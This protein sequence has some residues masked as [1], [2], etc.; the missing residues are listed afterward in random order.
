MSEV[1][2]PRIPDVR[3][4][5]IFRL[6][7]P[8]AV[9]FELMMLEGPSVQSAMGRL[10]APTLN[11]AAWG[12]A[13]S[14]ALLVESPVI[15]LLATAIALVKDEDSYRALRR[16]VVTL[17]GVCTVVT[18]L[19]AFT[20]LFDLIAGRIMGQPAPIVAA[21]RP[22]LQIMLLW[23]AA[24]AWRRFYQGV[25]V[26]ASQTRFVSLGTAVRLTV[27]LA[28]AGSLLKWGHRPGVEVGAITLMAA[29]IMEAIA[30]TLFA[31]PIARRYLQEHRAVGPE[32]LT[33]RAIFRFHTPLAA[34]TLLT[35]LAP[36][37][38]SAAL[39]RLAMPHQTLAA[40]PVASMLLLVLRGPG[41]ALQ[42]ITV[43]QSRRAEARPA[44][45]RFT[46]QVG[47]VSMGVTLLLALTPLL[48]HYMSDVLH[49][50]VELRSFVRIGVVLGSPLPLLTTL[51][52]W[53]RGVLVAAGRTPAV[54]KGMGVN[55]ATHGAVLLTGIL[56]GLPGIAVASVAFLLSSGAEYLYLVR[57]AVRTPPQ[58]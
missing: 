7:L 56:C 2:M 38:T 36:P 53:A 9:S 47:M 52:S 22:A 21:A 24:I 49:L 34:T 32:R 15:M 27:T 18:A 20:P 11:L 51:G 57:L 10:P 4:S 33:Q 5:S 1:E 30:V 39:A 26:K 58:S 12:L 50:P 23:T 16:F 29:V 55:L 44:L 19:V 41:L 45:R 46:L 43:S 35:L 31:L 17:M 54:Y 28:V 40:W 13:F 6:W 14:L 25:L 8:L 37:L 48:D 42:E 3:V